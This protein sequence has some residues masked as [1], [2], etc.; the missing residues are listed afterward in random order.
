MRCH[1]NPAGYSRAANM[2][3]SGAEAVKNGEAGTDTT[4]YFWFLT[5][6]IPVVSASAAVFMRRFILCFI[7]F[8]L[9]YLNIKLQNITISVSNWYGRFL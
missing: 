2:K 7:Q 3:R 1:G 9:S 5:Y 6:S 4:G 8:G